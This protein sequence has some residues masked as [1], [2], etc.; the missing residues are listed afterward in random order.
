MKISGQLDLAGYFHS[1][2]IDK[3]PY[4]VQKPRKVMR[5]DDEY[6]SIYREKR[7][8]KV[9]FGLRDEL[10]L[11]RHKNKPGPLKEPGAVF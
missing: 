4:M 3:D 2:M 5:A 11:K 6:G 7:G 9:H 8:G 10:K 1:D